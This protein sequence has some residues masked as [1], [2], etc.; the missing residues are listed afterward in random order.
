MLRDG[1]IKDDTINTQIQNAAEALAALPKQEEDVYKRQG[2]FYGLGRTVPPA[3][4]S[5]GCNYMRIPVA[6]LLVHMGM[7]AVSYTHLHDTRLRRPHG[8]GAR[9]VE[10]RER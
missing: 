4:V 3:I 6:L 1:Q 2:V 8:T 5:I 9:D 10:P 7:G